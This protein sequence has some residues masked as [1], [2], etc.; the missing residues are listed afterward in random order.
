MEKRDTRVN[1]PKEPFKKDTEKKD[2][3]FS[4][5]KGKTEHEKG[6]EGGGGAK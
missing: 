3:Q 5:E 2:D 6:G 4:K 1:Q